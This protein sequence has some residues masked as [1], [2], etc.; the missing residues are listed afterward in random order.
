VTALWV[1]LAAGLGA[2]VRYLTDGFVQDRSSGL[3]PFGTT[4]VNVLGSFLLGLVTG[5]VLRAVAPSGLQTILGVGFCG[6]FTTW[7]TVTWETVRLSEDA[8]VKVALRHGI[9]SMGT[10]LLAGGAGLAL[11]LGLV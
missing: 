11:G 5:L 6:G 7:S 8:D 2:V 4:I 1:G 9:V 3:F 10:S